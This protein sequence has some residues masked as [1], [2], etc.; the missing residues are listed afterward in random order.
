MKKRAL[1]ILLMV[2]LIFTVVPLASASASAPGVNIQITGQG[3]LYFAGN[4]I[5]GNPPVYGPEGI[6]KVTNSSGQ[7]VFTQY[8]AGGGSPAYF[9]F[10]VF[11]L[12]YDTY[13]I[14]GQAESPHTW[15]EFYQPSFLSN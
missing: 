8:R 11:N 4:L 7:V 15:I 14:N 1:S 2:L 12:P 3:T 6:F 10:K 9:S 5:G 13:T